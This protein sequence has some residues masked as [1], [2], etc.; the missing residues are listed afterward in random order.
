MIVTASPGASGVSSPFEVAN[1]VFVDKYADV[2][3]NGAGFIADVDVERGS[4]RCS[5]SKC[6]SHGC[7]GKFERARAS[8]VLRQQA[9]N[10]ELDGGGNGHGRGGIYT[11]Q[12]TRD[13]TYFL[14]AEQPL[15]AQPPAFFAPSAAAAPAVAPA[16]PAACVVA[17]TMS[18]V[19][20]FITVVAS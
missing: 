8:A 6:R 19:T 16:L 14:P 11:T 1:M 4:R 20:V 10:V 7:A 13:R 9:R 12:R 18:A 15:E 5:S 2:P 17:R 3:A